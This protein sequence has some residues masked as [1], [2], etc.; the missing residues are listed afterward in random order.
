MSLGFRHKHYGICFISPQRVIPLTVAAILQPKRAYSFIVGGR[1]LTMRSISSPPLVGP[2]LGL[3]RDSTEPAP[4]TLSVTGAVDVCKR[5]CSLASSDSPLAGGIDADPLIVWFSADEGSDCTRTEHVS[6]A[7]V[8][9]GPLL[10]GRGLEISTD[11]QAKL[12]DVVYTA[13]E[14]YLEYLLN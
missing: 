13:I 6:L 9:K 5:P 10:S 4:A 8:P 1:L 14:T 7:E 11:A 3:T 2:R 12:L